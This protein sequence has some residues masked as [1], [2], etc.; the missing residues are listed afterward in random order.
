VEDAPSTTLS[1]P[2][3]RTRGRRLAVAA[4]D[5]MDANQLGRRNLSPDAFRL[6]LGRRYNRTKKSKAEAQSLSVES[7][8][9]KDQIDT[10]KTN[11]AAKLA[12]EHS[13]S[14]A[15]VKRA[16]KFAEEVAAKPELQKAIAE[17][18][19]VLQVKREMKEE[20]REERREENRA[21]VAEAAFWQ[22]WRRRS[23]RARTSVTKRYR[24][25]LPLLASPRFNP[26]AGE[27]FPAGR[28]NLL[29]LCLN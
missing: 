12:A 25:R 19:P 21:K 15:T 14:E 1:T 29:T 22:G 10:C 4:M 27:A 5:W 9:S 13:V 8:N 24:T 28:F 18:K 3:E 23:R 20:R 11:T 7:R 2:K 6:A 16:G 26:P 17:R